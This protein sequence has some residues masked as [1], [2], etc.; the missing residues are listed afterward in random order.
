MAHLV[1]LGVADRDRA[2]QALDI[3]DDLARRELLRLKDAAYVYKDARGRPRIQQTLNVTGVGAAGGAL[4]GTLI[5]ALFLSPVLGLAV[6][7][8]IGAVAGRLT[9]IGIDDDLIRQIG[10]QLDDGRAA[11]FLLV[12]SETRDRVV[13]A[14]RPLEPTVLETSLTR[15]DE[16]ELIRALHADEPEPPT[17]PGH[18]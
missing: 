11:V 7:T 12:H 16:R 10:H 6:G 15:D 3:A 14:L 4:W 2:E 17:A 13:E 9:D 5:G 18:V 1:V 8:A